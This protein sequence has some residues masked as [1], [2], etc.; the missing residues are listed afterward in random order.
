MTLSGSPIPDTV[1]G[2]TV[3]GSPCID[4]IVQRVGA[5]SRIQ[6]ADFLDDY[7]DE[8]LRMKRSSV[9]HYSIKIK[10]SRICTKYRKVFVKK[11]DFNV[12]G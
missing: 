12:V 2:V 10:V 9:Y 11:V 6:Y 5:N 3:D 8:Q 7:V 4:T 1:F